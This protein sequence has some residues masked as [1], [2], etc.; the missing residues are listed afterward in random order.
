MPASIA[1]AMSTRKEV[2]VAPNAGEIG[3]RC[4]TLSVLLCERRRKNRAAVE[5]VA[6]ISVRVASIDPDECG[7][8]FANAGYAS[9]KV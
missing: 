8:Y 9:V 5:V 4:R 3:D 2:W 1:N 6:M 7:N